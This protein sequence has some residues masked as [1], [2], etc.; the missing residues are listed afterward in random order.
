MISEPFTKSIA[1]PDKLINPTAAQISSV[2]PTF[3]WFSN[4]VHYY[5][6]WQRCYNN[7][8][9]QPSTCEL[10]N[11]S[12]DQ[13]SSSS[14]ISTPTASKIIGSLSSSSSRKKFNFSKLAQSAL[15]KDNLEENKTLINPNKDSPITQAQMTSLRDPLISST[16][17]CPGS[18][19]SP[20]IARLKS[21]E[22]SSCELANC[23][24]GKKSRYNRPKRSFTCR[25][26]Q[27][28]FT[29]SYNL[30][31]HVRTHTN[32]RPYTCD[33]CHKSFRR[34]DHL[35]DHR[36]IHMKEKPFKCSICGKGFCQNRILTAHLTTHTQLNGF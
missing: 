15:E 12:L 27:R 6:F 30:M 10:F 14:S 32:E 29:K 35:R 18:S 13:V 23:L 24:V 11:S 5:L 16:T 2:P 31:I 34:Q 33:T 1:T 36:Y 21:Q 25:F 22:T 9:N 3:S 7:N 4:Y 19:S 28:Q 8:I 26:C 20:T 17:S